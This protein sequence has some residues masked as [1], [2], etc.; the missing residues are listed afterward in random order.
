MATFL[1]TAKMNPALVA[2]VEKAVHGSSPSAGRRLGVA[3]TQR[4]IIAFARVAMVLTIAYGIYAFVKYRRAEQQAME[5]DRASL[6]AT[7]S[8][9]SRSL[10]DS[11]KNAVPRAETWLGKL[12]APEY[13]G[14]AIDGDLK[15][16]PDALAST[17]STRSVVYVRGPIDGFKSSTKIAETAA[18]STKD[19][20]LLCMV[21][22]PA[23]R[24]EK[25]LLD[26]VRVAYLAGPP[27][28]TQTSNVR[29]LHDAI[30][31]L[32]FLSPTWSNKV[33]ASTDR[34]E[35]A[36]LRKDLENAPIEHT[37]QAAKAGLLLVAIDEPRDGP[38]PTE[39]DGERPHFV[40]VA[41][42]DVGTPSSARV[43]LSVRK[44]VDP[45]W[46]SQPKRPTYALGLDSCALAFDIHEMVRAKK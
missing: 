4:R 35:I 29:S 9:E 30:V 19:S 7:V 23:A 32:P 25:V 33:K 41:L 22:P 15:A 39:L 36:Q 26:K 8:A 40:R 45:S 34:A 6:L 1:K 12:S 28:E 44:R 38:G 17:L 24:T 14:D 31:G 13:I 21:A 3:G 10:T 11:E 27:L 37:K 43:L 46:I 20:L 5:R 42:I 18:A 16:S 2:R